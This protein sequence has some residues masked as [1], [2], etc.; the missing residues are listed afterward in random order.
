MKCPECGH[1]NRDDAKFCLECGIKIETICPSCSKMLPPSAKFCDECG[2][3]IPSEK[4]EFSDKMV[5]PIESA[6]RH[7]TALF[8]DLSGYTAMSE[9]MDPEDVKD[10]TAQLFD[11]ITKII[12]KYDGFVEKFV[13]DAVMALFGAKIAHED[14]PVRAIKAALEIHDEVN[15]ISPQYE[16][17]IEQPLSM[18][19]GINTGLVVT[20]EINLKEGTH[21]VSGDTLNIASRLSGI[22]NSDEIIVG[23]STYIQSEG[24][25][26]YKALEPAIV[27][28]KSEPINIYKVLS[29]KERPQKVHRLQGVRANLIGRKVELQQLN[30]GIKSLQAQEGLTISI[31]GTAGTG[32]SRLVEEFKASLD[33]NK[34][35][36][37]EGYAFPYSQN[38]PYFPLINL[39]NKALQIEEDDSP[40]KVREKVESGLRLLVGEAK[41]FVPYIGSLYSLDYPE[42]NEVS[43]EFWKSHL[44]KAIEQIL[45]ALAKSGPTVIC[46]DDLHWADPSFLDL[47][48]HLL[49]RFRYNVLFLCIYRPTITLVSSEQIAAMLNPYI[50]I[51]VK[52]L[53]L[54]ESHDMVA[55]ILR[56]DSIP[57]ELQNFIQSKVE[58]NPFYIEEVINSLIES[59]K[60]VKVNGSW[61][62]LSKITDADLSSTIH[63]VIS[64]RLDRL[65]NET[66]RILQEASVIGRA[67]YYEIIKKITDLKSGIEVHLS[68]LERL[69]F[70]KAKSFQPDIEYIFKHALTQEI[71]YSGLLKKDRQ[72]IHERTGHVMEQ[73]FQDRLPEF[74]ETLA[75]HFKKGHSVSKAVNYLVQ[76]G[77]KNLRRYAVNE[78]HQYFKEAFNLLKSEQTTSEGQNALIIEILIK[79]SLV[80]YYRGDFK[81]LSRLL[82][83]H[84]NIAKSLGDMAKLGM[85]YAWYGFALHAREK[86]KDADSYLNKAL[87]IG[88]EIGDNK[89]VGY[90]NAWLSWT[91]AEL[92]NLGKAVRCGERAQEISKMF[93][94][95]HYL[96]FKSLGGIAFAAFYQGDNDR[97]IKIGRT[98]LEYGRKYSNV[99]SEVLGFLII[100]LSNYNDG[101]FDSAI[102]SWKDGMKT[103]QDPFYYQFSKGYVGGGYFYKGEIE[104]ADIIFR[105]VSTYGEDL[106]CEVL[107]T[108]VL[109][110]IGAILMINGQ[111]SKG[112]KLIES[113]LHTCIKNERVLRGAVIE[114]VLGRIYLQMVT[115]AE[116]ASVSK[117]FKNIGFI[118][119][120]VP[121]ASKKAEKHFSNVLTKAKEKGYWKKQQ[122]QETCFRV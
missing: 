116:K 54:S 28:G 48:R 95:D 42:I 10:I 105:E 57:P 94:S 33:L 61:Q 103:A 74:Y 80:Y 26:E 117:I 76:S 101:D 24:Y 65:E 85:F 38:I 78:S 55:S 99:R 41:E 58:G 113:A 43:P 13:G 86:L 109:S 25:F 6:R 29:I 50:E 7:V 84:E 52:D 16:E 8:S 11:R 14:D 63:G 73:L 70:I 88:R 119:K 120:N 46:L 111:M 71:V 49:L 96:Y 112:L 22:G 66:K 67:F 60:M 5:E 59:K 47:F 62:V 106:G 21:G 77:E 115:K 110:G 39:L 89:L 118:V 36:W 97:V 72:L 90:A 20:G 64:S 12:K 31:C 51:Q 17:V 75:Y 2:T 93:P 3:Q 1:Q 15:K 114:H 4:N 107:G 92:G 18:H 121:V 68:G 27:K 102:Q 79:W 91:C 34:I 104:K 23:H 35:Q 81:S 19:T 122:S 82:G 69:D 44:Q 98:L 9:R 108:P 87:E 53:S 32:K 37:L 40:D 83:E 30:D 56:T 45:E 100:G